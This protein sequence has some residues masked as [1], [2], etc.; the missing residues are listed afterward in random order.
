MQL[1]LR[2]SELSAL[3]SQINPHFLYNTL[4]CMRSIG[5]FYNSPEIVTISTAMTDIFR[6]SIKASSMVCLEKELDVIRKYLSI[7]NIRFDN[8]FKVHFDI[9]TETMGCIIPKMTLQP[10]VENAIYH[11]LEPR[12]GPGLLTV[13]SRL[14]QDELVLVIEDNGIGMKPEDV[15]HIN[16]LLRTPDAPIVED[17]SKRSIGLTNIAQ[18]ICLFSQGNCSIHITS[19]PNEGTTVCVKLP[20]KPE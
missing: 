5:L 7:I 8:R 16:H 14:H 17:N 18:R 20:A 4:E 9:A 2:E 15:E 10:I 6:Y 12:K 13:C 3:Q 1:H 11:G 19:K